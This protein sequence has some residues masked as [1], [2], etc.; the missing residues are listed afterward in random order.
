MRIL[1]AA[2]ILNNIPAILDTLET[3]YEKAGG[4]VEVAEKYIAIWENSAAVE[5][6]V[7]ATAL[8]ETI[9]DPKEKIGIQIEVAEWLDEAGHLTRLSVWQ[10]GLKAPAKICW[11]KNRAFFCLGNLAILYIYLKE[12]SKA[13]QIIDEIIRIVRENSAKTSGL[14]ATGEELIAEGQ[15]DLALKLAEVIKEPEV[16]AGLWISLALQEETL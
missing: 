7:K 1:R 10:P 14:G 9:S 11:I 8:A 5:L 3:V 4:L 16:Q 15:P 6:L 13:G 12:T 2:E